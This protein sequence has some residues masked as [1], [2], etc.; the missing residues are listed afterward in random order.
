MTRLRLTHS[1]GS[2]YLA[3]HVTFGKSRFMWMPGATC[4]QPTLVA[5]GLG[6]TMA[7]LDSEGH[8]S[9]TRNDSAKSLAEAQ[10][11]FLK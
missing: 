9:T 8:P 7:M 3:T 10:S 4:H 11:K 6:Y 5:T 1:R 2:R